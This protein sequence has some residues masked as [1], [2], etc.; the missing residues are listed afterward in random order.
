M[1]RCRAFVWSIWAAMVSHGAFADQAIQL[2][3][4]NGYKILYA[5]TQLQQGKFK[6]CSAVSQID[7]RPE[8]GQT[9]KAVD[10]AFSLFRIEN[11][12]I[13]STIAMHSSELKRYIFG[14][15]ERN[16]KISVGV[17]LN[18]GG[19]SIPGSF[20]AVG[21]NLVVNFHS[22]AIWLLSVGRVRMFSP[23]RDATCSAGAPGKCGMVG[24]LSLSLQV[25]PGAELVAAIQRCKI[26]Y[27]TILEN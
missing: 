3:T 27:L 16:I 13:K 10:V 5:E 6:E 14:A 20:S 1:S 23:Q 19:V 17:S 9:I 22:D 12:E 25:K 4:I 8:T 15:P 21:D 2:G 24:P 7:V 18:F 11:S 26:N